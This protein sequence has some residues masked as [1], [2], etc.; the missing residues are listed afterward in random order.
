MTLTWEG[1]LLEAL[2]AVRDKAQVLDADLEVGAQLVLAESS[3]LVPKLS[4]DLA[5]SGKVSRKRGGD[6]TVAIVYT[7]P[8]AHWIHENLTFRHPRGGQAK[9]LETALIV[10]GPDAINTAGRAFWDRI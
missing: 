7:S 2:R 1:D 6:N 10:K 5:D 8:Y 9:F 4:G 3:A